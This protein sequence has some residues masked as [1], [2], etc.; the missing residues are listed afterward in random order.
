MSEST[1]IQWM[2]EGL[3]S[4]ILHLSHSRDRAIMEEDNMAH[5]VA[6][7]QFQDGSVVVSW[8]GFNK[9]HPLVSEG[10]ELGAYKTLGEALKAYP[11]ALPVCFDC[12]PSLAENGQDTQH[13]KD[14]SYITDGPKTGL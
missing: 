13:E 2:I 6:D 8:Q 11:L 12:D 4:T 3:Q 7:C 9:V 5:Q 10:E 14:C 1:K